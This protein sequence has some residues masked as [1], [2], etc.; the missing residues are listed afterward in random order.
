MFQIERLQKIKQ[1]LI[2]ERS[3][4]VIELSESLD[5]SEITIRRDFEKLEK[6]GFL[7]RTHGGAI[8]NP[9]VRQSS[10][11]LEEEQPK[12]PQSLQNISLQMIT[13]G[14]MCVDIVEDYDVVFLGRCPSNVVM[15]QYLKE[16]NDIVVITNYLEVLNAMSEDK[17]NKVILTGGEVD[18]DKMI[19][20]SVNIGLPF[21]SMSVKKAFVH[22]QGLHFHAGVTVNDNEDRLIYERLK[23]TAGEII[24]I[25]EGILFDKVGLIKIDDIENISAIV[26]DD[27][28]PDD[29]KAWLYQHGIQIYQKF[30]L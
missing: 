2:A 19:M 26:T 12:L 3:V 7:K 27:R 9:D 16:K 6:D 8:L 22:V 29:Y 11:I 23:Q 24:I 13:L 4:S 20:R 17:K 25:A 1:I 18:Y 10:Y 30:N 21:T 28:I 15:A 14:K 5:V